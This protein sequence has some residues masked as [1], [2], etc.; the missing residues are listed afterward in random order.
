MYKI[1]EYTEDYLAQFNQTIQCI[2]RYRIGCVTIIVSVIPTTLYDH[3]NIV[4]A[5]YYITNP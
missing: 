4:Y 3:T 2:D 5:L 1:I